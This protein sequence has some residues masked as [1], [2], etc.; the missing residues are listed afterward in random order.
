MRFAG[1]M[2]SVVVVAATAA[3]DMLF[4]ETTGAVDESDESGGFTLASFDAAATAAAAAAVSS[5]RFRFSS[6]RKS[7]NHTCFSASRAEA[8][9]SA[10]IERIGRDTQIIYFN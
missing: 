9:S 7:A 8:R 6:S 4:V 1:V 3:A 2:E 5:L 10:Q